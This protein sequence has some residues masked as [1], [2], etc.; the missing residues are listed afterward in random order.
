MS[1]SENEMHPEGVAIIGMS[2]KFPGAPDLDSFWDNIVSG[3]DTISR[4]SRVELEAR[5]RAALE[6]GPDYVA[7]H[8]VLKDSD[9]F[10]AGFFGIAPREADFLDPQHRLFLETCWNALEDGGCDPNQ[11]AGQIG[12]FGGCSLNTYLLANLSTSREFIDELTGNYQ[13]GEFQTALGNDKDF[14]CTRVA[15]KLNLRGPCVTVQAACATSLVA[16]SQACQSLLTYQCDIALAGGVSVTFPQHRGYVYQEGSIGS[17]DGRCRPFD[18]DATGTVFG[19]GVGV[20]LLKRLE[21]ALVDGDRIHAVIR[22]FAVNNDGAAKVGYMAP[23][24]EGQAAVVA[25]AQ[26]MAGVCADSITYLEA[27]GTNAARRSYRGCRA[28]PG[29][30]RRYA[31][32]RLLRT[33]KHQGEHRSSGCRG[34]SERADQDGTCDAASDDST[35]R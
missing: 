5:D 26:A 21:D 33:G 22:G 8:G 25:A 11:F 32:N 13:V 20:V 12:V 3:R 16:I 2:G 4:F 7:A 31:K 14:L 23:G 6:F 19:H 24:V 29:L 1:S 34:R 10:D 28:D 17:R 35:R 15:Y 27:H 30:P 9:M 18:S